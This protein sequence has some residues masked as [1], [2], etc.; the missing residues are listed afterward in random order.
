M[1]YADLST[2]KDLCLT[3]SQD[4][5]TLII[6]LRSNSLK[7]EKRRNRMEEEMN[8]RY[9]VVVSVI[10]FVI[11]IVGLVVYFDYRLTPI[12]TPPLLYTSNI[13]AQN[14]SNIENATQGTTQQLNLILT[15]ICSTEIA[16]LIESFMIVGYTSAISNGFN[17]GSPWNASAQEAVFNYSFSL[18][19]LILQPFMSNSTTITIHLANNAPLGS[20]SLYINFGKIIFLSAPNK[21]D[22]PYS[23]STSLVIW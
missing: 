17:G 5:V 13:S 18:S 14:N 7:S 10:L 19:K 20:Y 15:S 4:E 12:S 11:V 3:L 21:Y 2:R 8:H 6:N 22:I 16:I 9:Y 1:D 23:G